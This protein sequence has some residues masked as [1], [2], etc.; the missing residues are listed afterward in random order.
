MHLPAE[1]GRTVGEE[2]VASCLVYRPEEALK[3]TAESTGESS[4]WSAKGLLASVA[5]R[6]QA[7]PLATGE[8]HQPVRER[9][10][11]HETQEEDC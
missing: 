3:A 8:M 2:E 1:A 6:I 7:G 5:G 10:V 4:L 11:V 9:H